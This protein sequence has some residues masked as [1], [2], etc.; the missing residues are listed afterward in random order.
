MSGVP[1]PLR[2]EYVQS[3]GAFA[4][5]WFWAEGEGTLETVP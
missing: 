4:V 5:E 2:V 1:H 3:G